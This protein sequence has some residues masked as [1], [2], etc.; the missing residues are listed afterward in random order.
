MSLQTAALRRSDE[1]VDPL[2]ALRAVYLDASADV[3]AERPDP[4]DRQADVLGREAAR[5][6]AGILGGEARRERPVADLAR[7]AIGAGPVA[8]QDEQLDP[9]GVR[10][11]LPRGLGT[12]GSDLP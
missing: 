1:L 4:L 3:D 10:R 5:E 11:E 6:Q 2:G 12:A 7:A 8:V 9:G